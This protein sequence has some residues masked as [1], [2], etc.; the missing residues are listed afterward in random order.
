MTYLVRVSHLG[1]VEYAEAVS[2]I[3][4]LAKKEEESSLF[5]GVDIADKLGKRFGAF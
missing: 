5:F 2:T 1:F 3:L 4:Q